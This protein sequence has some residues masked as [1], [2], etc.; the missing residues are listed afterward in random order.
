MFKARTAV[1]AFVFVLALTAPAWSDVRDPAGAEAL[2]RQAR[3]LVKQGDFKTACPKFAESQRLDPGVGTLLNLAQCE[4]K[5]GKIASAWQHYQEAIDQLAAT[6][7]RHGL[8]TTSAKAIS[9]RVPKLSIR[10]APSAAAETKVS[11]DGV[12]LG[13]ASLGT[14]L[15]VDPGKHV[16]TVSAPGRSQGRFEATLGEGETKQIEV[17]AGEIADTSTHAP[18]QLGGTPRAIS[19]VSDDGPLRDGTS[20]QKMIGF[21]LGGIGV[22]GL[23]L[24]TYFALRANS[25]NDEALQH[26]SDTTCRDQAGIDLTNESRSA[27]KISIASFVVGG[28]SLAAGGALVL[29]AP[30]SAPSSA[31]TARVVVAPGAIGIGIGGPW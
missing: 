27:G 23:G 25:K 13:A 7:P 15:P 8:A 12:L 26:C 11:R 21:A 28:L 4:E 20:S 24:G 3:E 10:L 30:K 16:V 17:E 1:P 6:D 19:P 14:A 9:A 29:T 5:T 31:P 22:V 18:V 2:F